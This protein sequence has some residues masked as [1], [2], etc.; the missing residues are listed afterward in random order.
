MRGRGNKN[1]IMGWISFALLFNAVS[2]APCIDVATRYCNTAALSGCAM[3]TGQ[4]L[5]LDSGCASEERAEW[6]WYI[7]LLF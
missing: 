1:K 6:R 5:A 4:C 3:C 7:F 2:A